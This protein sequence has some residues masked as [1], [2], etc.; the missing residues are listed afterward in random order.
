VPI[1]SDVTFYDTSQVGATKVYFAYGTGTDV[2]QRRDAI[3]TLLRTA[4]YTIKGEDAEANTEAEAEF[5]GTAHAGSI[6][7]I[8]REGCATQLRIR[9]RIER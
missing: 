3:A 5:E 6:Q 2:R 4:G 9:Y 8:H 7:V 1:P